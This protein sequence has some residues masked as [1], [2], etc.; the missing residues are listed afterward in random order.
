MRDVLN[1]STPKVQTSADIILS[2][3]EVWGDWASQL[4]HL[5]FEGEA[6]VVGLDDLEDLLLGG[7]GELLRGEPRV[8]L[9]PEVRRDRPHVRQRVHQ[10]ARRLLVLAAARV[11]PAQEGS[12]PTVLRRLG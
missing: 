2:T 5:E 4:A 3:D 6:V 11:V 10:L 8:D 1:R 12:D 7:R 9:G